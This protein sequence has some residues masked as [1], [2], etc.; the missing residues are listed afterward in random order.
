MSPIA[1]QLTPNPDACKKFLSVGLGEWSHKFSKTPSSWQMHCRGNKSLGS[2]VS[3]KHQRSWIENKYEKI[4]EVIIKNYEGIEK[5]S[6]DF[7]I[8]HQTPNNK[9][10]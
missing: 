9:F 3:L 8:K 4:K 1:H 2:A 10:L 5:L 7:R 6:I